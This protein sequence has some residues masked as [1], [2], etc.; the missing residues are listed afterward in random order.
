VALLGLGV[1]VEEAWHASVAL[2]AHC[3]VPGALL[4]MLVVG[5]V[6][7]CLFGRQRQR[8]RELDSEIKRMRAQHLTDTIT[9]LD[10]VSTSKEVGDEGL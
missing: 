1:G 10:R 2:I 9:S 3:R 4:V 6:V 7:C 8:Y 5:C